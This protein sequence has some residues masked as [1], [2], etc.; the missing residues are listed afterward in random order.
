MRRNS[1]SIVYLVLGLYSLLISWYYN[2]S[3]LLL[4]LHYIFWPIY[5]IYELLTG[6]LSHGMWKHIPESYFK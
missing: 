3:I 5:L 2:H 6:H 1:S 4:I